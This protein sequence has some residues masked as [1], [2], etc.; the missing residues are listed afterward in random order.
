MLQVKVVTAP[1]VEPITLVEA[2]LHCKVD[3]STDDDLIT[4][5]IVAAREE[6]ERL[7]WRALITQTLELILPDWPN[8]S[9]IEMPRGP[10]QS[11][12]SVKYKDKDGNETT[13]PGANYLVGADS[14]PGVLALAW[15]ASW[16]SVDLYPVEPI[17]IRFVAGYGLAV[18]VPQSLKQACL[19]LVA[20]WYESRE[21]GGDTVAEKS[22]IP[23]GVQ[24]LI[25]SY[26]H[27]VMG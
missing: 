16:P 5:L 15:N 20:H 17:R 7:T 1:A 6:I 26:R 27:E 23:F 4:A 14:V 13:W 12:T 10:L 24:A 22:G 25:R 3:L 9:P 11:I 18:A 2:K 19:L 21:A 8:S